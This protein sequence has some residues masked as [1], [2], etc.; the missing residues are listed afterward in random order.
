MILCFCVWRSWPCNSTLQWLPCIMQPETSEQF[1]GP[2]SRNSSWSD[3]TS[4]AN[5]CNSGWH[6]LVPW[7]HEWTPTSRRPGGTNICLYHWHP[8][9]TAQEVWSILVSCFI[10]LW[11]KRCYLIGRIS[12]CKRKQVRL[13]ARNLIDTNLWI[14]IDESLARSSCGGIWCLLP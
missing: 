2:I 7:W 4:K 12:Y 6:W 10:Q 13:V 11:R 14:S 8:V 5:L 3:S 9:P 1:W